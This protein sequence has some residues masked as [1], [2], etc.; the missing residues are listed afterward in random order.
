MSKNK[1]TMRNG[2]AVAALSRKSAGPMR[3][4]L[5]LRGNARSVALAEAIDEGES[6]RDLDYNELALAF[7]Y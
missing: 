4:R 1:S 5:A 3:H 2:T 6:E 7:E